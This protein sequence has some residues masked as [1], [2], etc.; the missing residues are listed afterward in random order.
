[1]ADKIVIFQAGTAKIIF[2]AVGSWY[3]E[4]HFPFQIAI[5]VLK[6]PP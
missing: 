1:L 3:G 6:V 5:A 4:V 2:E